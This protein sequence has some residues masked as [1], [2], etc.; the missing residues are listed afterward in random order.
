M[1]R[2]ARPGPGKRLP[3]DHVLGQTELE[4]DPPYFVLEQFAQRLD[5]FQ[6]HALRQAADIVM[7]LDGLRG[8]FYRNRFDDIRIQRSLHQ[9][10]DRT[11]AV[12]FVFEDAD[13]FIADEFAF[14]L[15]IGDA[16]QHVQETLGCIDAAHVQMQIVAKHRQYFFVLVL[17]QQSGIDEDAD[18][19][20][21]DGTR[22]QS[23]RDRR[24]HAAADGAEGAAIADLLSEFAR[25][26]FS[27]NEPIVQ[28]PRA[29]AYI[30]DESAQQLPIHFRCE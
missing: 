14:L 15:R 4:T 11:D 8:S 20:I 10:I 22:H 25:S 9:K 5:Q 1:I 26:E 30:E 28:S 16:G 17:S 6:L 2:T 12:R 24:I 3:P 23:R 29:A 19:A 7:R 21:A 13:E 18:Q 27:M